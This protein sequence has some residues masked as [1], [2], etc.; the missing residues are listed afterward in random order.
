MCE[1]FF[2]TLAVDVSDTELGPYKRRASIILRSKT[3]FCPMLSISHGKSWFSLTAKPSYALRKP[4]A[5]NCVLAWLKSVKFA[6]VFDGTRSRPFSV[7]DYVYTGI[8]LRSTWWVI[9]TEQDQSVV[10]WS[11][12]T[13]S[14]TVC[15]ICNVCC[16]HFLPAHNNPK[17]PEVLIALVASISSCWDFGTRMIFIYR[18]P[19]FTA[20]PITLAVLFKLV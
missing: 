11:Q 14:D 2:K 20:C 17:W 7:T 15:A 6:L 16:A 1:I 13:F 4:A 5:I 9:S 10:Y 12:M 19:E 8:S 18:S 3:S